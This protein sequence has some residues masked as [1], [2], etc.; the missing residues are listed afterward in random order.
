[1][2]SCELEIWFA[3]LNNIE[4]DLA[5][6]LDQN[7]TDSY[8]L[9]QWNRIRLMKETLRLVTGTSELSVE[10]LAQGSIEW[11]DWEKYRGKK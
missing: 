9:A 2:I 3:T 4:L 5:F 10:R 11:Y 6:K 8:L 1:M 7:P